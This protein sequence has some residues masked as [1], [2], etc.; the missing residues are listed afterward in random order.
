MILQIYYK[1][2]IKLPVCH[3]ENPEEI[4][5]SEETEDAA[6]LPGRMN[7]IYDTR[8]KS[9]SFRQVCMPEDEG[10]IDPPYMEHEAELSLMPRKWQRL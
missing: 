8:V 7:L 3:I 4:S 6:I 10:L 1:Y 9:L 5:V 2:N